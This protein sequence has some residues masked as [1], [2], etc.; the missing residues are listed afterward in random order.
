MIKKLAISTIL[1]FVL[2]LGFVMPS[3][4][5]ESDTLTESV[6]TSKYSC[7]YDYSDS[8]GTGKDME[9]NIPV[10]P[11]CWLFG[12]TFTPSRWWF[13]DRGPCLQFCSSHVMVTVYV[14]SINLFCSASE[15]RTSN[16]FALR[17]NIEWRPGGFGSRC[18]NCNK[19]LG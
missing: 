18:L 13:E 6:C 16:I 2:V 17:H 15:V 4:A 9:P 19:W 1:V 10:V 3:V 11:V 7:C 14:C 12:H 8:Y 5:L